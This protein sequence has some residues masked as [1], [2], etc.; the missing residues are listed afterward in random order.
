[1]KGF[2]A[3]LIK[4]FS[5]IRRDRGTL[6]FAFLVPAFQLTI[7]GYAI[8]VTIENIP[9]V[10]L[11]L[12]QRQD[13]REFLDALVATGTFEVIERV[14]DMDSFRRALSAGW[15]RV[16]VLIPPDYSDKLLRREQAQVQVLIDGSDSQV[17]T[18]ALNAVGLL[19]T[20]LSI[21][22]AKGLAESVELGP[23]RTETGQVALPIDV[24]PRLLFNPNLES[25]H[26]FVPGLIA[27]ILQ[28]VL[29]FLTSFSIVRE[30]EHGTL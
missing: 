10:V 23:A 18:T 16:G 27:I 5:H 24:R 1:V 4:E 28:V 25:S 30:R 12:D 20:Q 13:S 2:W 15:A 26:F 6:V 14:E 11:N 3:I 19:G 22:R 7:F 8:D 29:L 9:V 21:A 17:A